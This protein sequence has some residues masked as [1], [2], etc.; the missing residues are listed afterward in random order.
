MALP[1]SSLGRRRT[2]E[3]SKVLATTCALLPGERHTESGG[4]RSRRRSRRANRSRHIRALSHLREGLTRRARCAHIDTRTCARSGHQP[5][6][7]AQSDQAVDLHST[8]GYALLYSTVQ[9]G[10]QE[11]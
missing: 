8:W 7:E 1:P 5:V 3:T 4:Y 11:E 10:R 2:R 6:L 9:L